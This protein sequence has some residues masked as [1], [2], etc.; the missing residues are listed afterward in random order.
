MVLAVPG[1]A[2][3]LPPALEE[4]TSRGN[5]VAYVCHGS[6]CSAPIDSLGG[7]VS[8]LRAGIEH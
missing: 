5:A 3:D 6:T 7:L 8:R 1:D 4:K 2:Q